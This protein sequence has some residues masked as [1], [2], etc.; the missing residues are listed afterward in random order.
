MNNNQNLGKKRG[1]PPKEVTPTERETV[2]PSE[3][4][5]KVGRPKSNKSNEE[6][7]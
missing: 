5:R 3:V 1:R 2:K 7:I 4:K 6:S